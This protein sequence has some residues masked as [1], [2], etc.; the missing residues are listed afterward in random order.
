MYVP[1]AFRWEDQDE[2]AAMI[3][4]FPFAILVS[5]GSDHQPFAT[6]IPLLLSQSPEWK[7]SGH[8]AKAN[9]HAEILRSGAPTL[10]IFSG[11]HAYVS[12]SLYETKPNVPTWNYQAIH[13][14]GPLRIV[15]TSAEK[16]EHLLAMIR[17]LDPKLE[18]TNPEAFDYEMI[19][20]KAR[21]LVAFEILVTDLQAKEKMSQNR[22][23]QDRQ[24][25]RR[26]FAGS[27]DA[28]LRA[29]ADSMAP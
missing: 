20:N 3:R 29:L 16:V 25:V 4:A 24:A 9:P 1:S 23:E 10:A 28:E 15:D 7:I 14:S 13:V 26:A 17:I 8:V 11:P 12:P 19:E 5:T 6:H 18:E 22:P 27:D 2:I 21:G